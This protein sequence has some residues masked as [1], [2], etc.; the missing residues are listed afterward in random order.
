M[1]V[2]IPLGFVTGCRAVGSPGESLPDN[3]VSDVW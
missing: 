2:Q 3:M 1:K